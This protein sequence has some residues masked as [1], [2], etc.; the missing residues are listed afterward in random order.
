MK[1]RVILTPAAERAL[2]KLP[3]EVRDRLNRKIES[4]AAEPR[5]RGVTKL[6]GVV[7]R[8]RVRSGIY[9]VIYR[10][11]DDVLLVIVVDVGHR[12]EAY[13]KI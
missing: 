2:R 11:E 12:R 7:E 8:W 1:Y 3:P 10:I 13:R 5:P 6:S 4:L 9:R